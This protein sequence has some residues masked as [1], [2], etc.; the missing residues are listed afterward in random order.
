MV[1][2]IFTAFQFNE[3]RSHAQEPSE[4]QKQSPPGYVTGGLVFEVART[5][6][7]PPEVK[8]G[9]FHPPP[10]HIQKLTTFSFWLSFWPF[11]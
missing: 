7:L 5:A 10:P 4:R 3:R 2:R 1:R 8:E 11:S 6:T 9:L